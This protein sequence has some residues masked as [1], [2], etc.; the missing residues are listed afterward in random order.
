MLFSTRTAVGG[1]GSFQKFPVPQAPSSAFKVEAFLIFSSSE[2][3]IRDFAVQQQQ[4]QTE[5]ATW[6][7]LKYA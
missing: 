4:S 7:G 1:S 6:V 3:E 5:L 2:I